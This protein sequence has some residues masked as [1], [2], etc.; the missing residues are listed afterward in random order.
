M[1]SLTFNN[2]SLQT[3]NIITSRID[4]S[5]FPDTSVTIFEIAH[6][7]KSKALNGGYSGRKINLWG[8][9]S[10]DTMSEFETLIDDFKGYLT[11]VE[12][13]LD[14][15]VAGAIRRYIATRTGGSL[16]RETG[17]MDSEFTVQFTCSSPFGVDIV[18]TELANVV[19]STASPSTSS[20]T[21]GGNA[22]YQYPIISVTIVSATNTSNATVSISNNNNGQVCHI[23]RNFSAGEVITINPAESLVMVDGDEVEFTGAIP[24]FNKGLGGVSISDTF[25]SREYDYDVQQ[26]RYWL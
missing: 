12:K 23:T 10:H 7:N 25:D 16:P 1:G 3:D 6:A 15:E 4:I 19:G 5:E 22:E 17:L 18:P 11:G 2:N 21:L 9:I 13:P 20:L 8:S 14:V 24:I 26:Y